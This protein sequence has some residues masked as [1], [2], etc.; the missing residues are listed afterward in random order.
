MGND[1]EMRDRNL[2]QLLKRAKENGLALN[3]TECII[4]QTSISLFGSTYTINGIQTDEVKEQ[5]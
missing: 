1:E 3:G 4:K 5:Y 2:S